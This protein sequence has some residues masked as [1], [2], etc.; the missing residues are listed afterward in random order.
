MNIEE[1]Y[2]ELKIRRDSL[3]K[4]NTQLRDQ[5]CEITKYTSD[6]DRLN[7]LYGRTFSRGGYFGRMRNLPDFEE[8]WKKTSFWQYHN[9]ISRYGFEPLDILDRKLKEFRNRSGNILND[10][11]C[12][13]V[14][15]CDMAIW[16][17]KGAILHLTDPFGEKEIIN[18]NINKENMDEYIGILICLSCQATA[19]T[20]NLAVINVEKLPYT[21][22]EKL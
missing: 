20:D 15:Y 10:F 16:S 17:P 7:R 13:I 22:Y 9:D 19:G 21:M 14:A 5:L 8:Q 11:T 2:L 18:S 6:C 1:I 3:V 4:E 12:K